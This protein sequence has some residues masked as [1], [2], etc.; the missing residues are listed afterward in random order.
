MTDR[1]ASRALLRRFMWPYR[2]PLMLAAALAVAETGL[3]LAAPWPLQLAV[4]NAIGHAP[5]TGP[6][7]GA[8]GSLQR[9]G[10]IALGAVA[11][12]AILAI[13]TMS[14][15]L[16]YLSSVLTGAASERI[17]ADLRAAVHAHLL[18]LSLRFHDEHRT[19]DL[20]TRLT[21][22]VSR[23][24]DALIAWLSTLVP[25]LLTLVGMLA[26]LVMIDPLVAAASLAVLPLLAVLT[27]LRRR[28]VAPVQDR[29]RQQQG[30]LASH[31]TEVLRNVRAVQAF[32]QQRS[33]MLRFIDRNRS[34]TDTNLAALELSAR[35]SP[36]GDIVLAGGTGL[37]LLLGVMRVVSGRMTVGV[38]LVV[39][40]YLGNVYSPIRSLT[41]LGATLAKRA[42]SQRRIVEVLGSDD[43]VPEPR[44]P[45]TLTAVTTAIDFERVSFSYREGTPVLRDLSL[46]VPVGSTV[47]LVG[48]SG[49]G[50]STVL[51]LL[52]RLY[53]PDQGRVTI[54]G[55]DLRSVSLASLRDRIALVPQE[56]WLM[57]GSIRDN[58]TLGC[59]GVSDAEV[60]TAA[61]LALVDEFVTRLPGGY[62]CSVGE[63][64]VMLSGGQRRRLAIARALLRDAAILLL[65]EPTTGLDAGAES[66]VLQAM[67]QASQGRTVVLVTHSMRMAATADR[68]AVLR[69]GAIVEVGAPADLEAR[70][71]HYGRLLHLQQPAETPVPNSHQGAATPGRH[72]SNP[73]RRR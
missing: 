47:A 69:D 2:W 64:G 8:L 61:R 44:S 46:T 10:P 23:V 56:P 7:A 40:S 30:L 41:R 5:V 68:V 43:A 65:D 15:L 45:L 31:L 12:V 34:A 28:A 35:Y 11:G 73:R 70:D 9:H 36:L 32:A 52:L 6:L 39:L 37:V 42:A 59:P 51:S 38:L 57:D 63:G 60:M 18:R 50:K 29:S 13:D 71:G 1:R 55:V 67:R 22:D 72:A 25:Q 19:G 16:G 58:I 26:I 33:A 20:V 14:A 53:D 48:P 4:D 24:E 49:A 54:D 62:D 21:G 27:V 66:K 3:D 17:G